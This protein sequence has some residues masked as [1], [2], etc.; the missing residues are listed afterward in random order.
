MT[1]STEPQTFEEAVS[2]FQEFLRKNGWSENLIWVEPTDLLLSGRGPIYV[3]LP[4]PAENLTHARERFTSGMSNGLGILFRTMC[5]VKNATCCYA[6]APKDPTE[7]SYHLM[8]S[9]LKVSALT[10]KVRRSGKAVAYR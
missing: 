9:G 8:G 7:Q 4:V 2:R 6:W 5:E 10:D 3:K 1:A